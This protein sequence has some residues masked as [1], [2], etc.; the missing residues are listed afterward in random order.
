MIWLRQIKQLVR[1][2]VGAEL[3]NVHTHLPAKIVSYTA[4]TN[5]CSVQ[6][7][8]KMI[9]SQDPDNETIN[10]PVLEDVPVHQWGSGKILATVPPAAGAYGLLHI[11]ERDIENW[12]MQ[13]DI[14]NPGSTRRFDL[15]DAFFVP[16]YYPIAPDGDNGLLAVPVET[17]RMSIRT[18]LN[19]AAVAVVDNN[20]VE[21]DGVSIT[22]NGG[23]DWAVQYTALK[24]AFDQLKSDMNT[25]VAVFNAHVHPG[26]T[27][28]AGSTGTTVTPGSSSSADM[29]GAKVTT[30]NLPNGI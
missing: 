13:G 12:I 4:A 19:T 16:G 1:R 3:A 24:A 7:C 22:L 26:V 18:R 10:L 9:R 21:I 14:Q 28:G 20:T 23:T 8:I 27:T 29:S 15:S 30:V 2:I 6:P 5:L 11:C 17:D 25:F